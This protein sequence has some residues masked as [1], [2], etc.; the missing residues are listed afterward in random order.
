[1]LALGLGSLFQ[2]FGL[3]SILNFG[4]PG[5]EVGKTILSS[6]PSVLAKTITLTIGLI[7]AYKALKGMADIAEDL[8]TDWNKRITNLFES[9]LAGASIGW[10]WGG[11]HGAAIG[12]AIGFGISLTFN[13]ADLAIENWDKLK[14]LIPFLEL[15]QDFVEFLNEPITKFTDVSGMLKRA[16]ALSSLKAGEVGETMAKVDPKLLMSHQYK[17][18]NIPTMD[19]N[20]LINPS[21]ADT[22]TNMGV[23]T[24]N[25][26]ITT[27]N[28]GYST[29]DFNKAMDERDRKIVAELNSS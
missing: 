16:R 2:M 28:Y 11:L 8:T 3:G 18:T 21:L 23:G 19:T 10:R 14:E 6:I 22:M 1:M 9:T 24:K 4:V 29:D 17:N 7:Y 25:I 12:A 15:I 26:Y 5:A 27:N 13:L 20:K